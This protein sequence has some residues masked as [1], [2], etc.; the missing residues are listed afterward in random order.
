MLK[1]ER[2]NQLQE[3]LNQH[4]TA[5]IKQLAKDLYRS[6]T[7]IRRD[8][9]EMEKIGIVKRQYGYVMLLK[10]KNIVSDFTMRANEMINEKSIV[11]QKALSLV[12]HN[13]VIFL[14]ESSTTYMLAKLLDPSYNLTIVTNSIAISELM[15]SMHIKTFCTGGFINERTHSFIGDIT[16]KNIKEI[17]TNTCFFSSSGIMNNGTICDKDENNASAK[18][19]ILQSTDKKIYLCDHT[20]F[21][22]AYP[23]IIAAS[24]ELDFLITDKV[25][26]PLPFKVKNLL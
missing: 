25:D 11:A 13:D 26:A 2:I 16:K 7:M 5:T 20:K 1:F 10:D 15:I 12:N 24:D 8:L 23:Y 18:K 21:G 19:T 9:A 17:F 14:D 3:Y 22:V 4:Q 6:E